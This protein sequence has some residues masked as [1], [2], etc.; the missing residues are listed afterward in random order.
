MYLPTTFLPEFFVLAALAL[1]FGVLALLLP[2][3][4]PFLGVST[5]MVS[6]S[7]SPSA[8]S[9]S[10]SS[11]ISKSYQMLLQSK[12]S[13]AIKISREVAMPTRVLLLCRLLPLQCTS[14]FLRGSLFH[15]CTLGKCTSFWLILRARCSS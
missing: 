9:S 6:L 5:T 8:S 15:S 14:S 4:I 7:S 10:S 12:S 1:F 11:S 13:F 3:L 2:L